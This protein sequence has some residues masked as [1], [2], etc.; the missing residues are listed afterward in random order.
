MLI[1]ARS[2]L[3]MI[4]NTDLDDQ[5]YLADSLAWFKVFFITEIVVVTLQ[6]LM[7]LTNVSTKIALS[8]WG[9]G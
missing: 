7:N 2:P 9:A 8:L 5:R 1:K 4:V 6:V 3:A